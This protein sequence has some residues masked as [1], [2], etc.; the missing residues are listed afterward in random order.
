MERQGHGT[1]EGTD[2]RARKRG[3]RLEGRQ[4]AYA[5]VKGCLEPVKHHVREFLSLPS[6]RGPRFPAVRVALG[7]FLPL[8]ALIL[9]GRTD[10]TMCAIFG[11]LTGVF[12]RSEPH[13]RRLRHQCASGG[14]M[15]LTVLAG[16]ALSQADRG[17]WAV[18][19][20]GTLIAGCIS[21]AADFLRIRPAGPFTYIFAFTATSAAPF[22]GTLAEAFLAAG[23]SAL[24]AVVLGVAGRLHARRHTPSV[25][26]LRVPPDWR[27][28]LVH[29][30]R[31]T[32]AVAAAGSL[33]AAFGL[34]HG[35]WAMLAA[36]APLAAADAASG[37]KRAAHFILGT[38]AGV[39]LSALL[40]QVPWTPVQLA[41]LLALLQFSGEIY[42]VRHYGAAMVFLT[43][44]ALMMTGFMHGADVWALTL[45]RALETTI[46]ALAAVA[47]I[48][49]TTRSPAPARKATP[50]SR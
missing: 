11:S 8:L 21:V 28:I 29:S 20:L 13:W 37:P 48:A 38:Y 42:V 46:G 2:V 36:C 24:L 16:V 50:V 3:S 43:P 1:D 15:V 6:G 32:L 39:L 34:G 22:G 10:L 4:S 25:P 23:A 33:S 45:D 17:P 14:L 49:A 18:V 9:L 12:G 30:G 27:R 31:Y 40:L 26:G 19:V 44:V 47:V 5:A 7:L 41:V 35:Y